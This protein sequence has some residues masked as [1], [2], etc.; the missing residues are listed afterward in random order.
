MNSIMVIVIV[1]LI[2]IMLNNRKENF[3]TN[4]NDN[5]RNLLLEN[6]LQDLLLKYK[7]LTELHLQ[8]IS[9]KSTSVQNISQPSPLLQQNY[10]AQTKYKC[11]PAATD[12]ITGCGI[13]K[14]I[15][16]NCHQHCLDTYC[17]KK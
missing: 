12:C 7:L 13:A 6:L 14:L 2:V 11:K 4:Q 10:L 16:P 17:T 1:L 8:N 15:D 5:S 9:Q 3:K